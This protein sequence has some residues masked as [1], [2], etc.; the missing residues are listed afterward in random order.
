MQGIHRRA[1]KRQMQGAKLTRQIQSPPFDRLP[2]DQRPHRPRPRAQKGTHARQGRSQSM[3]CQRAHIYFVSLDGRLVV[4]DCVGLVVWSERLAG[5]VV[6]AG[7]CWNV[8]AS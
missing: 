3:V 1:T 4:D 5:S 8:S 2:L 7:L 6:C